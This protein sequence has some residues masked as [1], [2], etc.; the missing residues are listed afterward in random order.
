MSAAC[1]CHCLENVVSRLVWGPPGAA[2]KTN[3]LGTTKKD[4][5]LKR[6]VLGSTTQTRRLDGPHSKDCAVLVATVIAV[7]K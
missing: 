7:A 4:S 2:S 1:D 3:L 5:R 6:L